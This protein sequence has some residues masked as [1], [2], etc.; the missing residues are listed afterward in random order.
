[1]GCTSKCIKLTFR[2]DKKAGFHLLESP[3]SEDQ[4]VKELEDAYEIS[5]TLVESAQLEWWLSN[6]YPS[7]RSD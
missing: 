2:I 3:L 1:M 5:A 6:D 4:Q 7:A